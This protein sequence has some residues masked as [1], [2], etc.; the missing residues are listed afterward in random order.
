[1]KCYQPEVYF[2]SEIKDKT[3]EEFVEVVTLS[4]TKGAAFQVT[5]VGVN[6]NALIDL[7]TTRTCISETIYNQWRKSIKLLEFQESS[8]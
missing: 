8:Q 2:I 7:G 1:M 5:V 4:L 3:K 6:C